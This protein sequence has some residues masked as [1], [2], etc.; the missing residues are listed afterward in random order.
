MDFPLLPFPCR[1]SEGGNDAEAVKGAWFVAV[2]KNHFTHGQGSRHHV[3]KVMHSSLSCEH[4]GQFGQKQPPFGTGN[5]LFWA[6]LCCIRA[7]ISPRQRDG[8][9]ACACLRALLIQISGM[10]ACPSRGL[11]DGQQCHQSRKTLRMGPVPTTFVMQHGGGSLCLI[12][13]HA[14]NAAKKGTAHG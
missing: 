13:L 12:P 14:E 8:P 5:G 1:A 7:T 9:C 4:A 2:H 6:K 11:M 3:G 10:C